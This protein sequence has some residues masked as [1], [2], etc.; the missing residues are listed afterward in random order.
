MSWRDRMR[1]LTALVVS[2]RSGR[3]AAAC[4]ESLRADWERSGRRPFDLEVIVVDNASPP[5]E[6]PWLARLA[7]GGA[8]VVE[9]PINA[10]FA[11]GLNLAWSRSRGG[12]GGA[13][14]LLN[15][16]LFFLPGSIDRL[17]ETLSAEPDCGAIAPRAFVDPARALLLPDLAPPTAA[18]HA[19]TALARLSPRLARRF[20]EVWRRQR[21]RGW[22]AREPYEAGALPGACLLLRRA[23][24][25]GL[26]RPMDPRYPL[27]Y[28]DADLCARLSGAG[29][30]LLVEPRAEILHHWARSSGVGESFE[31]DPRA[32]HLA[33]RRAFLARHASR[34]GRLLAG[35][36]LGLAERWPERQRDRCPHPLVDLG[37]HRRP[38][39]I[40]LGRTSFVLELSMAPSFAMAA[41]ALA[42][43]RGFELAPETWE[44]LFPGRYF[45]RASE[46]ESGRHLGAWTFEKLEPALAAPCLDWDGRAA[47]P[48]TA[49]GGAP[50]G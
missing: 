16:D 35:A 2:Y 3:F 26:G 6:E 14:A 11:G 15:A 29:L 47:L 27:Y 19:R 49:S 48:R 41:G 38:P 13:V 21:L 39:R 36:L 40:E 34:G 1:R 5:G 30:R 7:A 45:A 33:S 24:V 50:D 20:S 44:W 46:R 28:E 23:T 25:E 10:G 43:G 22:T 9:S 18:E 32:R 8:N 31:G 17:L 12:P 37:A 42:E 4:V